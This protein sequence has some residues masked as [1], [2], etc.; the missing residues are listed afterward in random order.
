MGAIDKEQLELIWDSFA[1]GM[2]SGTTEELLNERNDSVWDSLYTLAK[3]ML[4]TEIQS[5]P[6]LR[7]LDTHVLE[8]LSNEVLYCLQT[9]YAL[10]LVRGQVID[11]AVKNTTL[12]NIDRE[13]FVERVLDY[14]DNYELSDLEVSLL[15]FLCQVNVHQMNNES[16]LPE[17]II[18]DLRDSFLMASMYGYVAAVLEDRWD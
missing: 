4:E 5:N 8:E 1:R 6:R 17:K 2:N 15:E 16:R 3:L 13:V 12:V 14:P 18:T 10:C 11:G 7:N 9:G